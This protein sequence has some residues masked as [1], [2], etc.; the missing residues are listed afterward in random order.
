MLSI[1]EY[2]RTV[3]TYYLFP[4]G[5]GTLSHI[6]RLSLIHHW[7]TLFVSSW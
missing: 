6:E 5:S 4:V 1:T 7:N 2:V 3:G